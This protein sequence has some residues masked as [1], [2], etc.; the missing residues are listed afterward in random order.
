MTTG[1]SRRQ[2]VTVKTAGSPLRIV[3]AYSDYPGANLVNNLNLI[4]TSP[5]GTQRLG[6]Q[7]QGGPL[8]FDTANNV[9]VVQVASAAAGT[10]TIDVIGSNVPHGPQRYSLVAL[11]KL[12]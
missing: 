11:G 8:T 2:S 1:Q 3:L 10:W 6:N 12:T 4:V 9:E 5:D 7:R